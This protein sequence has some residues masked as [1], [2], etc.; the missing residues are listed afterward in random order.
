MTDELILLNE[1]DKAIALA[2][3]IPELKDLHSSFT[4]L[5]S[6]VKARGLDITDENKVAE[7]ILRTERKMG[8]ELIRT[9][10]ERSLAIAVARGKA[11]H[12]L[13]PGPSR[14]LRDLPEGGL[15]V[16]LLEDM[17]IDYHQS[18]D[19]QRVARI[20]EDTFEALL[21]HAREARERLAKVNFYRPERKAPPSVPTPGSPGF[22]LLRAGAYLLL[23]W[24]VDD[25]G[26]GGPTKNG[27]LDLPNDELLTLARIIQALV[28]AYREAKEARS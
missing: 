10:P 2:T 17:G 26:V 9:W 1:A 22:D 14:R 23:G 5:R 25:Q 13:A 27:L 21:S 3:T 16:E 4:A 20:P 24:S 11:K 8:A 7:A 28:P 6:W 15:P 19:W 18:V 12:K